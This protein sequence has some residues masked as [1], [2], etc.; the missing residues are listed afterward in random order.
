MKQYWSKFGTNLEVNRT[1]D[2]IKDAI[3]QLE[4]GTKGRIKGKFTQIVYSAGLRSMQEYV[5]QLFGSKM[6]YLDPKDK[7]NKLMEIPDID[8]E[9]FENIDNCYS[10]DIYSFEIYSDKYKFRIMQVINSVAFPVRVILDDGIA[11]ELN[12][13]KSANEIK[14][15]EQME[16][17]LVK[18]LRTDKV[19]NVVN[20]ML[21]LLETESGEKIKN[22]LA[23]RPTGAM[24]ADIAKGL[25]WSKG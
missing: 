10:Q 20:Q 12:M 3:K 16:N 21:V 6:M 13:S 14:S 22:Y 24:V 25:N 23:A 18:V 5:A 4:K 17:F 8:M 9:D 7:G 11:R 15:N 2:I 19:N 1:E